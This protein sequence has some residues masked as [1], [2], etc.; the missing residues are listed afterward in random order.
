MLTKLPGP[1]WV[2]LSGKCLRTLLLLWN[3]VSLGTPMDAVLS[4]HHPS[5]SLMSEPQV[6]HTLSP[7]KPPPI[8]SSLKLGGGGGGRQSMEGS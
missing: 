7:A 4:S 6:L 1:S 5:L 3:V 2:R 8:P